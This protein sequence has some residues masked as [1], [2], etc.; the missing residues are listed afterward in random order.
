[1]NLVTGSALGKPWHRL[2]STAPDCHC[3]SPVVLGES[4]HV[5][6]PVPTDT[7]E[8]TVQSCPRLSTMTVILSFVI[9][10]ELVKSNNSVKMNCIWVELCAVISLQL[11]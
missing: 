10:Y 9:Q 2:P 4:F 3:L 6:D 1:M 7:L 11:G 8:S 5:S